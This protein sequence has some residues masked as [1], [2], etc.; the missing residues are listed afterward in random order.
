MTTLTDEEIKV[1]TAA[2]KDGSLTKAQAKKLSIIK[3]EGIIEYGYVSP[4]VTKY[5]I[6]KYLRSYCAYCEKYRNT[7]TETLD[8]C[9]KC[10]IRPKV[11]DYD[12]IE[13]TGCLQRCHPFNKGNWKALLTLIKES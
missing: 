3:I 8:I 4:Q 2:I 12:S 5:P 10:P 9:G 7:K 1:F 13:E 6:L 11:K